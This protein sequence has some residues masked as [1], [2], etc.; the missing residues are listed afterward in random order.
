M[1][2]CWLWVGWQALR[3]KAAFP[4]SLRGWVLPPCSPYVAKPVM[5]ATSRC[6][7]CY[8]LLIIVI[9]II[10]IIYIQQHVIDHDK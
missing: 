7:L 1:Q 8:L 4:P 3:A 5:L 10:I 2:R 9:I 6:D